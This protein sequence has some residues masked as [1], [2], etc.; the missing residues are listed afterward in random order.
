MLSRSSLLSIFCSKGSSDASRSS[1]A[2]RRSRCR[3]DGL[4]LVTPS[5][6]GGFR[7][8]RNGE[9]GKAEKW[10]KL[11]FTSQVRCDGTADALHDFQII[12]CTYQLREGRGGQTSLE[13]SEV[14]IV[15]GSHTFC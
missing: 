11:I 3:F 13:L 10:K 9:K 12:N 2:L 8:R 14:R 6:G 5:L 1:S 4:L 15:R 7:L